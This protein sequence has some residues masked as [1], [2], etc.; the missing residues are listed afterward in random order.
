MV[1]DA[2]NRIGDSYYQNRQFAEAKRYYNQAIAT[3]AQLPGADYATFQKGF[4]AGLERNHNEKISTL[5]N[6]I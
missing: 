4:V 1:L 5:R 6:L 2:N 3:G